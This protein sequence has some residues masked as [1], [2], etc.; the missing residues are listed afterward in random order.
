MP[1][2][3]ISFRFLLHQVICSFAEVVV[4]CHLI[5]FCPVV[6]CLLESFGGFFY[7][8]VLSFFFHNVF[9]PFLSSYESTYNLMGL[10]IET[11]GSCFHLKIAFSE[12]VMYW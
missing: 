4:Q 5:V 11:K 8:F 9:P 3:A 2:P 10:L 12:S 7:F 1:R 6:L